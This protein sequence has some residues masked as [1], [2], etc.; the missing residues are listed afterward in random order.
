MAEGQY[1]KWLDY[2]KWYDKQSKKGFTLSKNAAIWYDSFEEYMRQYEY[3]KI[4]KEDDKD[5]YKD[6]SYYDMIKSRS[7]ESTTRQ[8]EYFINRVSEILGDLEE[9]AA[10]G[11]TSAQQQLEDFL[12]KFGDIRGVDKQQLIYEQLKHGN[13]H[14]EYHSARH[15]GWHGNL[16]EMMT[17]FQNAGIIDQFYV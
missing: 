6:K 15:H 14:Y 10:S 3:M 11:D 1:R 4:L 2:R 17:Y 7:Y 9:R 8:T 5:A 13:L 16:M 12:I